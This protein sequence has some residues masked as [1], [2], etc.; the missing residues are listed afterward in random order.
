VVYPNEGHAFHTP[1]HR[2]D[3]PLRM[4]AWFNDNLR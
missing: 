4:I 1:A 2:K 3:V